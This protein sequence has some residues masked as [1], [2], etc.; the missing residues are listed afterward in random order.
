M[1]FKL[2]KFFLY[3]IPLTVAIVFISTLFPFIVGKYSFFRTTVDLSLI[4]FLLGL[5]F[6][7]DSKIYEERILKLFKS[8][9]FIAVSVFTLMFLLAGFFGVNPSFSFWSN[10]ERGEGGLQILHLYLFFSLLTILFKDKKNWNLLFWISIIAALLVVFYG[11]GA[12]LKYNDAEMITRNIGGVEQKEFSGKGGPL[13][14]TFKN[15]MGPNFNEPGYRFS[16]SIGNSSYAAAYFIFAMFYSCYLLVSR[17]DLKSFGSIVLMVLAAIFILFFFLSATRGAFVGLLI[18][19][20][21]SLVYLA[22]ISKKWRK[23]IFISAFALIVVFSLGIYSYRNFESFRKISVARIFDISISAQTFQHRAIMWKIAW[24]GFKERPLLGWGPEN[25]TNV[26]DQHYNTNYYTPGQGMGAW[27]DRAH[28]VIFD[29]LSETGIMGLISYLSIF[30]AFYWMF[31]K[32]TPI[33]TN[34]NTNKQLPITNEK[35]RGNLVALRNY[36]LL[37]TNALIFIIPIAYL[38]Q[39]LALFEVL[40]IYL[41][42]FLFMAFATYKFQD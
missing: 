14:Q 8:P 39:G 24:D 40:P 1:Y 6:A 41:N 32:K 37:V 12:S 26:F 2:S 23:Y 21:S 42:L 17:K 30:V 3:L 34:M 29:Y 22:W 15:F 7:P 4:F 31:F 33:A 9:I 5:L 25:Y 16:G 28:S 19:I 13:Y 20:L 36:Q 35:F 27:F 18:G 10:F 38:I 11:V